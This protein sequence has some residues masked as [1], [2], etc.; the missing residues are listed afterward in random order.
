MIPENMLN[1]A[2]PWKRVCRSDMRKRIAF[3]TVGCRL[4]QYETDALASQFAE[5]G[6]EVGPFDTDADVYVI[7][8]C[9]VTG[10]SDHKSRNLISQAIRKK[11]GGVVV[12]TGCLANNYK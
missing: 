6:F 5:S 7:N 8:T 4:N 3:K 12:V 9:T 11:K 2:T 1:F 10:H